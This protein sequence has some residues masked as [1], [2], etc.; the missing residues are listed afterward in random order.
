MNEAYMNEWL[1]EWINEYLFFEG[2]C[3]LFCNIT[4]YVLHAWLKFAINC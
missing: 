2:F 4:A 3:K 1:D